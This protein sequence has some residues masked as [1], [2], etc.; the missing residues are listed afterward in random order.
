MKIRF[1]NELVKF[2]DLLIKVYFSCV[3]VFAPHIR[4]GNPIFKVCFEK[5][6]TVSLWEVE[7]KVE[8]NSENF[9]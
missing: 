7:I 5:K 4:S 6:S 1:S 2:V 9:R 8:I 3:F